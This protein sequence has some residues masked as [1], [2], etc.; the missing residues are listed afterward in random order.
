MYDDLDGRRRAAEGSFRGEGLAAVRR[1]VETVAGGPVEYR[2]VDLVRRNCSR[3][4]ERRNSRK[5][6]GELRDK[7]A[8]STGSP[9]DSVS[10]GC[11]VSSVNQEASVTQ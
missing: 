6:V 8:I 11:Y 2:V 3:G 9:E 5:W 1:Q 7:D 10:T 4:R